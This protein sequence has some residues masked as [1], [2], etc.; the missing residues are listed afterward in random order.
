MLETDLV[1][2]IASDDHQLSDYHTYDSLLNPTNGSDFEIVRTKGECDPISVVFTSGTTGEPKRVVHSHRAAYLTTLDEMKAMPVYLWK[3]PMFHCNG[4]CFTWVIAA[5]GGTSTYDVKLIFGNIIRYNVTNLGV[6]TPVLSLIANA[7]QNP[8]P[9]KVSIMT[10]GATPPRQ[11]V[12]KIEE[13]I[14]F[15]HHRLLHI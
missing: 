12:L 1:A 14:G 9:F 2:K 10:G 13:L 8:L 11:V 6:A 4:W 3:V 7:N 15:N 5:L